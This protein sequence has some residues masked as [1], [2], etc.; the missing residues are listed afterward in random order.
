MK[1]YELHVFTSSFCTIDHRHTIT[2]SDRWIRSSSV[3]L[4]ITTRRHQCDPGKDLFYLVCYMIQYIHTITFHI[5]SGFCNQESKMMLRDNI[6]DKTMLDNLDIF[7]FA[8]RI[9]QSSFHF[10]TGN[11]LV[12]QYPEFR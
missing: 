1:L 4:S 11:I 12:M 8:D 5:G 3:H 9:Q 10:P 2:R 7:L 6:N